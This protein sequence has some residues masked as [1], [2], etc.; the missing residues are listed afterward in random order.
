MLTVIVPV[1]NEELIISDSLIHLIDASK[2][3]CHKYP[4]E[5]IVVD[6]GSSDQ[7]VSIIKSIEDKSDSLTFIQGHINSP[8]IGKTVQ[9]GVDHANFD[10]IFILPSDCRVSSLHFEEI[11]QFILDKGFYCGFPKLYSNSSLFM[12]AYAISQNLTRLKLLSH[13]VWTNGLVIKKEVLGHIAIPQ[14]CFMED[15]ILSDNLRNHYP[16][17]VLKNAIIVNSRKYEEN[18]ILKRVLVNGLIMFLY[19]VGI[20]DKGFLRKIYRL[21][22]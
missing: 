17:R 12:K 22:F 21:E 7:S 3:F 5:I 2:P 15:V 11:E 4:L 6:A 1:L 16:S 8:S 14:D 13:F 9:L 18:G 10:Y 20:K 19:R